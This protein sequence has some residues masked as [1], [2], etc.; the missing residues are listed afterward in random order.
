M[1]NATYWFFKQFIE[2]DF[3][4][5]YDGDFNDE[6]T[7]NVIGLSEY[8]FKH[9]DDFHKEK[10]RVSFLMAECFQ[11]IIRHGGRIN[12][13]KSGNINTGFFLTRNI[14]G[15]YF[16]ASGNLIKNES[17]AELKAQLDKINNLDEESLRALYV[18]VL[19]NKGFSEKGGAG[20]GLIEI[21]RKSGQKIEFVF[22]DFQDNYS[23]FYNQITFQAKPE[24]DEGDNIVGFYITEAMKF[25]KKMLENDIFMIQKGDFSD[26]SILPILD[27]LEKNLSDLFQNSPSKRGVYHVLVEIL[28][29]ISK[30]AVEKD[31][32]KDGIFLIRK[33]G[34]YFIISAGNY[35]EEN[36][37]EGLK[38]Q[39]RLLNSLSKDELKNRYLRA[40]KEVG[41]NKEGG[42]RIE[43]IEIARRSKESIQY[44]FKETKP[45][46]LFFTISVTV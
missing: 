6:I 43:L 45:G 20:L 28:Q 22:D 25:H 37:I 39:L 17:V 1:D 36:H 38:S 11:N 4:L 26:S 33:K 10:K 41:D 5:L 32:K 34:I 23:I 19:T 21:A 30:Y 35:V 13:D 15:R 3:C 7:D 46:K 8:N 18:D 27:I 31:G 2:D 24:M 14:S 42:A 9:Q 40:L 29:N 44:S 16:I 12:D